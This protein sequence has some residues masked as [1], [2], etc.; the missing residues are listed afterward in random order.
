MNFKMTENSG[1]CTN[2]LL[3]EQTFDV[4]SDSGTSRKACRDVAA[5]VLGVG[6]WQLATLH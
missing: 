6:N 1:L 5:D 3:N 2:Q 4:T